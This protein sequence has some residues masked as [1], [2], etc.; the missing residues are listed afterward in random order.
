MT[1][2]R[3]IYLDN[4]GTTPVADDV[5]AAMLP[6]LRDEYGNA[7]STTDLGRRAK[8]AIDKAREQV[9]ALI[10]ADPADIVFTSGGTEASNHAIHGFAEIAPPARRKIVTS[11]VEHPATENA[12][13]RLER[14]G[15]SVVRLP[16]NRD[17]VVDLSVAARE[18]DDTTALV[19]IIHAQ[20]EIGTLEPVG[21]LAALASK[22]R[23]PVHADAS[24]SLGK[25]PV[26]VRQWRVDALTI[27]GHKLY[28]P[29][30]IGA[31]YLRRVLNVPNLFDGAGQEQGRRPGTENVAYIAGL[32]EAC[33][34]AAKRLADDS[35][36][37]EALRERLWTRLSAAVPD[38]I[39]VAA[40]AAT[41]PNTLNVLFPDAVGNDILARLPDVFA[42]TGSACHAGDSKPSSIILALGYA[43][44]VAL[45][46]VRLTSGRS[47]TEAQIDAAADKLAAAWKSLR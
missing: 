36:R 12:C 10:D 45:G 3:P 14:G 29:K 37:L 19:T 21:E 43:P 40:G 2:D 34:I 31:L 15:Y 24:Q 28:A 20:N 30:G 27:A 33:A 35:K 16:V 47:T 22:F 11:V 8:A 38:L 46:A 25:V 9:A 7:S 5:L 32:G 1:G 44:D 17:G 13:K 39:R 18:I 41:L 6:Y 42:S 23:I 4:N 26:S